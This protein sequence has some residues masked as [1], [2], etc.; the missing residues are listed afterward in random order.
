MQNQGSRSPSGWCSQK[1][2]QYP[3]ELVLKFE[4]P[5]RLKTLQILSHEI[6]ISSRVELYYIPYFDPKGQPDGPRRDQICKIGHFSFE[7]FDRGSSKTTREMKT[8]HFTDIY[9]QYIK[10]DIYQ[11][12]DHPDNIFG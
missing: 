6:K 12:Y 11:P 3:Q 9:T 2:C 5:L 1:F 7:D 8:V 10:M 4:A